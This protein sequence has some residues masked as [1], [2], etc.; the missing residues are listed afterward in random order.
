MR[1]SKSHLTSGFTLIEILVVVVI[2]GITASVAIMAFGDFGK[3][4]SIEAEAERFASK[5]RLVRYHAILEALPYKIQITPN[6]YEILRFIPPNQWEKSHIKT[7]RIH[8]VSQKNQEILIQASG[9]VTP[10]N[11][12]FG[13]SKKHPISQVYTN[14]DNIIALK[15]VTAPS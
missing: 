10:F 2:L 14:S 15:K 1:T 4:R 7:T 8:L 11:L 9:E 3:S 12:I 5:L 6:G 13:V